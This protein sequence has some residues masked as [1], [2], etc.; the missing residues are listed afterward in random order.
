MIKLVR[1]IIDHDHDFVNRHDHVYFK[2][3]RSV[4]IVQ[5]FVLFMIYDIIRSDI[6]FEILITHVNFFDPLEPL[7]RF[8]FHKVVNLCH[9]D[10]GLGDLFVSV[11]FGLH[12][13]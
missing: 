4:Q 8:Q 6:T 9:G 11:E 10:T 5:Y 1:T 13:F 3:M 2:I 12:D 7:M